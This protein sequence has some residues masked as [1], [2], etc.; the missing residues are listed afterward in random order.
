VGRAR[1][2]GLAFITL[3]VLAGCAGGQSSS[4]G[5]PDSGPPASTTATSPGAEQAA[6]AAA[7]VPEQLRLPAGYRT[8]RTSPGRAQEDLA[9]MQG[10]VTKYQVDS[11]QHGVGQ[12]DSCSGHPVAAAARQPGHPGRLGRPHRV[13]TGAVGTGR[14]AGRDGAIHP[15]RAV[16]TLTFHG[17]AGR[18]PAGSP[19][20][21]PLPRAV[22]G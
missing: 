14:A 13:A 16:V 1:S 12:P 5:Q 22:P 8:A 15:P 20:P 10:F 3:A 6:P 19:H 7:A 18:G 21:H 4:S 11:F 2:L 17:K 9:A